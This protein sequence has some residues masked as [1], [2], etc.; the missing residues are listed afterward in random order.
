MKSSAST[1]PSIED[2]VLVSRSANSNSESPRKVSF[3][4]Q[5]ERHQQQLPDVADDANGTNPIVASDEQPAV[6]VS[7]SASTHL[8]ALPY[9]PGGQACKPSIGE[10]AAKKNGFDANEN[11][12]LRRTYSLGAPAGRGGFARN[13]DTDKGVKRVASLR[14]AESHG[15]NGHTS[16]RMGSLHRSSSRYS[17]REQRERRVTVLLKFILL[18][19]IVLWLPYSLMVVITALCGSCQVP[20]F[21]WNLGYW[22]CYL[23]S[24]VNPLCYGYG[25]ENFRRTFKAIMTTR[26]WTKESRKFLRTG[27]SSVKREKE[28]ESRHTSEIRRLIRQKYSKTRAANAN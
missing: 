19:F 14:S 23:N 16:L 10:C 2:S 28:E 5:Q 12:H 11:N 1:A 26:W 8:S 15:H 20:S 7:N 6:T 18:C 3:A 4:Q 9:I 13:A 22:L 24:T 25:N 21:A 27:R 17:G